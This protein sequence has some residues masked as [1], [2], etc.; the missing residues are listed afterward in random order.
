MVL[1]IVKCNVFP[2]QGCNR[3][4]ILRK[5]QRMV[6][7]AGKG[8]AAIFVIIKTFIKGKA[9]VTVLIN[10]S[11][12]QHSPSNSRMQMIAVMWLIIIHIPTV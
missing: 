8:L 12:R 11:T 9:M 4:C 10:I 6:G 3:Y 7:L 1:V 2:I 5:M